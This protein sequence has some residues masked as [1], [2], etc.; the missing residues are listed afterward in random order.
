MLH[1]E[2]LIRDSKGAVSRLLGFLELEAYPGYLED[3][4]RVLFDKPT[5]TRRR[6]PWTPQLVS[7]VDRRIRPYPLLE[8]Y[9]FE[10]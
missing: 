4:S 7:E 2:E 1:H 10:S 5:Q 9:S 3:C 6:L 8:G